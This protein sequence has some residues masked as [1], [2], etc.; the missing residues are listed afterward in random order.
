MAGV[1]GLFL[2]RVRRSMKALVWGII[3]TMVGLAAVMKAPVWY[4]IARISVFS[5]SDGWHRA[6]LID[7]TVANFSDWWLIGTKNTQAWGFSLGDVTNNYIAEGAKGGLLTMVLFILIIVRCFAALDKSVRIAQRLREVH[8]ARGLWVLGAALLAHAV[9]Y[10]S[11]AY[12]DQNFVNWNLLLAMISTATYASLD[13]S[14][15]VSCITGQER[16]R[17]LQ[18]T[19]PSQFQVSDTRLARRTTIHRDKKT[20]ATVR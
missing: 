1:T 5:A 18:L 19:E 8:T 2:W 17:F 16:R 3:L 10:T 7:R 11:V 12:F 9:S 14:R 4:I 6:Y 13:R 15:V 20:S